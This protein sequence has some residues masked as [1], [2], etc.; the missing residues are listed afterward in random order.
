[1]KICIFGFNNLADG[2]LACAE[3][4]NKMDIEV[5]FF[6]LM[7]YINNKVDINNILIEFLNGE[8]YNK[9]MVDKSIKN[10]VNYFQN[11]KLPKNM[12]D[13]LLFWTPPVDLSNIIKNIK[14]YYNGKIYYHNWD[15]TYTE[16]DHQHWINSEKM[17]LNNSDY[18]DCIFSVN[19][20]EVEFYKKNNKNA[21][22]CYSGFDES[23]SYPSIDS[24][25]VCDVSAVITNLYNC[26]IWDRNKQK[27]NRKDLI[28][29]IYSDKSINLHIY[30]NQSIKNSYPDAYKGF[31]NYNQCHKVFCNSRINLCIHAISIDGYLSERVPQI[32]GSSGLLLTDNIIG[33][34]FIPNED[35]ILVNSILNATSKESAIDTFNRIKDLLSNEEERK[36]IEKNGYLKRENFKWDNFISLILKEYNK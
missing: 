22:H 8:L 19:P 26:S 2:Y 16:I 4:M 6:P 23:F 25:Y 7:L 29:L 32:I 30:G 34:D 20:K 36:R 13:I 28:D 14:S 11:M 33:L 9:F 5:S 31:I 27:I 35:Y 17:L 21:L 3:S 24:E 18:F 15:P 10:N 1:M 12:P